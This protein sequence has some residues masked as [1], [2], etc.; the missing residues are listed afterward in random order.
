MDV[1]YRRIR[2]GSDLLVEVTKVD[3]GDYSLSSV[4]WDSVFY[5]DG[6]HKLSVPKDKAY[7]LDDDHY[8]CPV[9]THKFNPGL[10]KGDLL[11]RIPNPYFESGIKNEINEIKLEKAYLER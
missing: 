1:G 7:K 8:L 11:V 2:I 4:D 5:T 10:L 6:A 9:S 3:Q